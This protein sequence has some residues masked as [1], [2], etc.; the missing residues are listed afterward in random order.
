[1]FIDTSA[2]VAVLKNEPEAPEV[3]AGFRTSC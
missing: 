2:L 1:M 3:V